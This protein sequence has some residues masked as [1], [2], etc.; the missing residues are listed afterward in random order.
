MNDEMKERIKEQLRLNENKLYCS[1]NEDSVCAECLKNITG[2]VSGLTGDVS[3]IRGDVSGIWGDVSVIRGDVSVIR[4][5]VSEIWGDVS[6]LKGDVSV[7]RGD[8]SEIRGSVDEIMEVLGVLPE[9]KV[10]GSDSPW[11]LLILVVAKIQQQCY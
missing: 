8:V 6:G 5:D 9:D 4:G 1:H 3:V 2:N 11:I 7:I 10:K